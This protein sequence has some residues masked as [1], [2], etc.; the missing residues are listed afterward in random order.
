MTQNNT[1]LIILNICYG[2]TVMQAPKRYRRWYITCPNK[3]VVAVNPT[4]AELHALDVNVKQEPYSGSS[5]DQ[6]EQ[7]NVLVGK[8]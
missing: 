8:C 6:I 2:N 3:C 4:M 1:I 7:G 5:N